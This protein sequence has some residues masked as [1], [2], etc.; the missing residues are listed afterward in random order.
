MQVSAAE[1]RLLVVATKSG[2]S[3]GDP[4]QKELEDL[5][6]KVLEKADD[7][8]GSTSSPTSTSTGTS[9]STTSSSASPTGTASPSATESEMEESGSPS[10]AASR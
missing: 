9:G 5:I 3:L 10:P 4:D 8:G 1:G 6:N 7:A 2:A